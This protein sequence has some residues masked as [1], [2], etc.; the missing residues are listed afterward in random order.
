MQCCVNF[1]R[2]FLKL[3]VGVFSHQ[4]ATP[5]KQYLHHKFYH[6]LQ[7]NLYLNHDINKQTLQPIEENDKNHVKTTSQPAQ[8]HLHRS[9]Q[10][11][12]QLE[13]QLF[14]TY[15]NDG[16][17]QNLIIQVQIYIQRHLATTDRTKVLHRPIAIQ[18]VRQDRG[19]DL[20]S[21]Q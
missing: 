4:T 11:R 3:E 19:S 7:R 12:C 18:I 14:L 9:Q 8:A 15:V 17:V 5:I 2:G 1:V 20:L 16:C 10:S 13:R 6:C 21:T